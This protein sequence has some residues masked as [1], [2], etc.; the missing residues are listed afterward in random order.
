MCIRDRDKI[1]SIVLHDTLTSSLSGMIGAFSK[2]RTYTAK[3]GEERTYYTGTHFSITAD[4]KVRQHAPLAFPTNHTGTGGWNSKSVGIDIVTRAGGTGAGYKGYVPPTSAQMK[5]LYVLVSQLADKLPA[6]NQKVHWVD[7]WKLG[8]KTFNIPSGIVSHGMVQGNRSDATFSSYYLKLRTQGDG[9]DEAFNKAEQAEQTARLGQRTMVAENNFKYGENL[10][11]KFFRL[12]REQDRPKLALIVG[13]SQTG[14]SG[15]ELEKL[16]KSNNY[17]VNRSFKAGETTAATVQRLRQIP[18]DGPVSLVVVFTGGNNPSETFSSGRTEQLINT[19]KR[20]FGTPQVIIGVAPPAMKGDPATVKKVFNRESHSPEFIAKR[21]RM[22]A[23]IAEKAQSMGA[24]VVDPRSFISN[25][26]SIETGDGIH[27]TGQHAKK[28]A[29][30]IANKVDGSLQNTEAPKQVARSFTGSRI[31]TS[32]LSQMDVKEIFKYAKSRS[33]ACRDMGFLTV[34]SKGPRVEELHKLLK[35][36]NYEISDSGGEFGEN[37]LINV[38]AFQKKTGVR[39]DGCVGP[40]TG[41][42]LG[43]QKIFGGTV[44]ETPEERAKIFSK[45]KKNTVKR[46]AGM[47]RTIPSG[48][49]SYKYGD[50]PEDMFPKVIDAIEKASEKYG[51]DLGIMLAMAIYESGFNPYARTPKSSAA[52]LY[53]FLKS[54]GL[55]KGLENY[56]QGFYDPYKNAEA[57]AMLIKDNIPKIEKL[58]G[59]PMNPDDEYLIYVAHQQGAGGMKNIYNSARQ[60]MSRVSSNKIHGHIMNQGSK[61]QKV[62]MEGGPKAFLDF[63]KNKFSRTKSLGRQI[64]NAVKAGQVAE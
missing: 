15:R 31:G 52:G 55:K 64:A 27:L 11:Y 30:Q 28:F 32:E 49:I 62:Y 41:G 45:E 54:S 14:Y 29:S 63:Y 46:Y 12:L 21:D 24:Q 17:N 56:P 10:T 42:A 22:A 25:P 44:D 1:T 4:G 26:Q 7:R 38:I 58:T 34:G 43:M 59:R 39:I 19:I 18:A 8:G 13:D 23:A 5:A 53:A 2:P 47:I 57:G 51:V 50:I 3:S 40:E 35:N 20:R 37:T 33:G 61:L 6:L 9:H 16:L 60:G 36:K 48:E